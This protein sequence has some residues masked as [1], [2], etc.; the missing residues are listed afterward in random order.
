MKKMTVNFSP[1]CAALCMATCA[2]MCCGAGHVDMKSLTAAIV[3]DSRDRVVACGSVVASFRESAIEAPAAAADYYMDATAKSK[4]NSDVASKM[5]VQQLTD[6]FTGAS[7]LSG[8]ADGKTAVVALY[9]PWWDAILVLDMRAPSTTDLENAPFKVFDFAF[10]SGET[11]RGE[12]PPEIPSCRTVVPE[13]DPLSVELW[14]VTSATKKAFETMFPLEGDVRQARGRFADM[15][16]SVDKGSEMSRIQCRSA[17]RMQHSVALLKNAKD[18]G[19]AA[20]LTRLARAGSHYRLCTYFKADVSRPL[21]KTFSEL[22]AE[23][24]KGF[25]PYCYIP[26]ERATLYVLVNKD[27]PT[28]YITVS[29]MKDVKAETSSMEW[30]S[31]TLSDELLAAWNNRKE[32]AK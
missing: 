5:I 1:L 22:P 7:A 28:L 21:L 6:F 27:A 4:W 25:L 13:G 32:V 16:G 2:G 9:N 3:G 19:T 17:L 18:T 15:R 31:L 12:T 24:R 20:L 26:T 8:P 23:V 11:F 10:L 30:Y 29:L 14:R